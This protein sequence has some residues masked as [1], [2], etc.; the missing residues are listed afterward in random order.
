MLPICWNFRSVALALTLS[1]LSGCAHQSSA[2]RT[3]S[4]PTAGAAKGA[5]AAPRSDPQARAKA[6]IADVLASGPG[7]EQRYPLVMLGPALYAEVRA[8]DPGIAHLGTEVS[9]QNANDPNATQET[10]V[11]VEQACAKFLRAKGL[12]DFLQ[13]FDSGQFRVANAE[14]REIMR[15]RS[16]DLITKDELATVAV[17]GPQIL[18]LYAPEEGMVWVELISKPSQVTYSP[19]T[20]APPTPEQRAIDSAKCLKLDSLRLDQT[21]DEFGANTTAQDFVGDGARLIGMLDNLLLE[22]KN[23]A[24]GAWAVQFAFDKQGISKV[25][26]PPKPGVDP[27]VIARLRET[28]LRHGPYSRGSQLSF[29][30]ELTLRPCSK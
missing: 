1:A 21:E 17:V 9:L 10:R 5:P 7:L 15:Q 25:S 12:R 29:S 8:I 23:Q 18:G 30:F 27:S 16:P 11:C 28:A 2:A 26:A 22:K 13:P 19:D 4:P 6:F 24:S 20:G 3:N 14:A